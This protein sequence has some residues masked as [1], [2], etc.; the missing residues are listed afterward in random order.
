MTQITQQEI[1]RD[2]ANYLSSKMR[3]GVFRGF[4]EYVLDPKGEGRVKV[5]VIEV[6][7]DISE[8]PSK[9]LPWAKSMLPVMAFGV[10]KVNE[11]VFVMFEGGNTQFPLYINTASVTRQAPSRS[12]TIQS[13]DSGSEVIPDETVLPISMGETEISQGLD[14]P[15]EAQVTANYDPTR[16]VLA[17][18]VKGH[19]IYLDDADEREMLVLADRAGQLLQFV[20]NVLGEENEGNAAGR[21]LETSETGNQLGYDQLVSNFS[22]VLLSDLMAQAVAL[23]ARKGDESVTIKS[24]RLNDN[25]SEEESISPFSGEN[26]HAIELGA[27]QNHSYI[28]IMK[29]GEIKSRMVLDAN[30]AV[31][32]IHSK[33]SVVISAK[34]ITL[35]AENIMLSGDVVAKS[36]LAAD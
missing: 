4:V 1:L 31:V 6:Y 15:L 34:S 21:K 3:F 28:E 2:P 16:V 22:M 19:A 7:G 32:K 23:T 30:G 27:G 5:R 36:V 11:I 18:S 26:R 10:P 14:V 33:E 24:N 20:A 29:D 17:R 8:I 35:D 12:G 25:T 13:N 9:G